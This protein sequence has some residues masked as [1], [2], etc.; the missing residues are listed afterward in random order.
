MVNSISTKAIQEATNTSWKEWC[1]LFDVAGGAAL[2]HSEIVKLAMH[3]KPISHWWAQSVA[4]AYEQ[5][6]GRRKPGQK[7]DGLFSASVSRTIKGSRETVHQAWCDFA[8]KLTSIDGDK[9]VHPAS[10]SATPKRLYWRCNLSDTSAAVVGIE[11][12]AGSKVVIGVQHNKLKR[13]AQ[14]A[15]KK[16][17]W[18]SLIAECFGD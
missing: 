1:S 15:D 13:E 9:I 10:T 3:S 4:V 12:K 16:R 11:D 6:I 2:S 18:S 5:H 7:S 8:S 17:A 14:I